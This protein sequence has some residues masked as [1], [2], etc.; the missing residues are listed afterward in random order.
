MLDSKLM[1]CVLTVAFSVL[2]G[3]VLSDG[4]KERRDTLREL[5]IALSEL[6]NYIA[7]ARMPLPE[8]Y[9]KLS[10]KSA[11]GKMFDKM[12]RENTAD[13]YNLWE[14]HLLTLKLKKEDIIPLKDLAKSLGYGNVTHQKTCIDICITG[15]EKRLKE[16]ETSYDKEGKL[17]KKLGIYVGILLVIFKVG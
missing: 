16:A 5:I 1:A 4:L 15:L 3:W 8:I 13:T 7:G 6:K 2:G 11:V 9:V 10:G 12:S 14:K 17:Y